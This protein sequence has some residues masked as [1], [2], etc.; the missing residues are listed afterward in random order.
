MQ[1]SPTERPGRRNGRGSGAA[2][3]RPRERL[4][5]LFCAAALVHLPAGT[6]RA[7]TL[8]SPRPGPIDRPL[9]L[10]AADFDRDGFDDL[11][12]ANFQ[13]GTLYILI[14]QCDGAFLC[15]GVFAAHPDSPVAVGSAAFGLPTGGPVGLAVADL[16]PEDVDSDGVPNLDD[17]CPNLPNPPEPGTDLQ[18]DAD[19]NGIGDACQAGN[20]VNGN[21]VIEGGSFCSATT[22]VTCTVD[23]DCPAGERCEAETVDSDLDGVP[24]YDP[25]PPA[26]LDNCPA[27]ANA[28][29]EDADS[30]G[31]GDACRL[32]PDVVTLGT[33]L[34]AGS[35]FGIVRVDVND[36]SGGLESRPSKQTSVNPFDVLLDDFTA[37][38]VLD[39]IVSNSLFDVVQLFPG[40][41]DGRFDSQSVLSAG[42]GPEGVASGDLDGDGDIDLAVANRVEKTID[43]FLND[44]GSLPTDPSPSPIALQFQPSFLLAADPRPG[45][46]GLDLNGDLLADLIVLG[47]DDSGNGRIDVFLGDPSG[48]PTPAGSTILMGAGHRPRRSILRDLDADSSLDLAVTDFTGGQVQ[49]YSGTGGGSFVLTSTLPPPSL[50]PFAGPVDVAALDYDGDGAPDLAV[51]SFED[52]RLDLY[53]NDGG[54]LSFSPAPETPVSLWEG[55]TGLASFGADT[56]AANDIVLLHPGGSACSLTATT[57]CSTSADCPA[58]E[59]CVIDPP[60]IDLLSGIGNNFFRA[61]E[62][63][64]LSNPATAALMAVQDLRFDL[65]R[66]LAIVDPSG[67]LTVVTNDLSGQFSEA[68]PVTVPPNVTSLAAGALLLGT[69]HDRDGVPNVLDNCPTR[70]NPPDCDVT[71][72]ACAVEVLCT[73]QSRAPTD[74]LLKDPTT[75]Q[76][77]SDGNGI[78]DHC[79]MLGAT[80]LATDR[81]LDFALDYD[82]SAIPMI[83]PSTP[84]FDDDG[85]PNGSDN[86]PTT[87]NAAQVDAD[88]N[89]VG[90]ICQVG[91]DVNGNGVIESGRFCSGTTSTICTVDADC[92]AG[93]KCEAETVDGD[94]DGVLDYDPGPPAGLDNCP[95]V[96]NPGQEDND[97]DGVGN[98]C[99]I[100]A[101][102]DNCPFLTN[103]N[104][105]ADGDG[106]GDAC[107]D[108]TLD[109]VATSATG[110]SV[111]LLVGDGS[112]DLHA[113]APS[114]ALPAFVTPTAAAI[115]N[116]SLSCTLPPLFMCSGKSTTDL[117]VADAAAPGSADDTL[118]L[119]IGDGAGGFSA[120]GAPAAAEGDPTALAI[121]PDQPV[122]PVQS[123]GSQ[124]DLGLRFDDDATS[125]V[126][127]VVQPG[128]STVGIY[129]GAGDSSGASLLVPPPGL[130]GPLPASGPLVAATFVDLNL[131]GVEDLLAL[132]SGDSDPATP[133]LTVYIGIGN[134]LF[135]TDPSLNP[136]GVPDGAV[137]LATANL[138]LE[139]GNALPDVVLYDARAGQPFVLINTLGERA[140]ID[141]SG[142]VDGFDLAVLARAFGAARG[143]DFVLLADG[144]LQQSGSGFS[145]VLVGTGTEM[146]GH[147]LPKDGSCSRFLEPLAGA[148]GLPV[149]IDLDGDVDGE[150]LA[151]LASLFGRRL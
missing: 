52:N 134:G 91:N 148:Y 65:R 29:Q 103:N 27:A 72:P 12:V 90:D 68:D 131:D 56:L 54:G 85:V 21:G 86:C 136:T 77:D 7:A 46:T 109:L 115:G 133:N 30:D 45:R 150:D 123:F 62:P 144:T 4:L 31:V 75:Q 122:C 120:A 79:Q 97:S 104:L 121:A 83:A 102:L 5:A 59:T 107:Q 78:G 58:G 135:F 67:G 94:L 114:P 73:D 38:G 81:D 25:G 125:S 112:G 71:D 51:L 130:P 82:P 9:V 60:R 117:V 139:A 151:L 66:D 34:G 15:G 55:S 116:F 80:C 113:L 127:A 49:I 50:P 119:L 1:L 84:D 88:L 138:D 126:L 64:P 16:N 61:T 33:S 93:E 70:Y 14:N 98:A 28:G 57:T 42:D 20:D 69:D 74:C 100:D 26:A 48:S 111:T 44:G 41:E 106:V 18:A 92:P 105:D 8:L 108:S 13:A 40:L 2:S 140:D 11:V 36:G 43:L 137:F 147:D 128:T 99:V 110:G 37:N 143:E 149:D 47:Q 24:D 146:F 76:C 96:V 118:T 3:R 141:G 32:S 23:A 63:I 53:H 132:S 145:A 6:A 22:S 101:A 124:S 19:G 35:S 95:T 142:R 89:G 129:L 39:M 87:A 10:A 17:N